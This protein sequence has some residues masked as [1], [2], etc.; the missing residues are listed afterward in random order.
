M[1]TTNDKPK[2]YIETIAPVPEWG[3]EGITADQVIRSALV[4]AQHQLEWMR[5]SMRVDMHLERGTDAHKAAARQTMLHTT[6][7][8]TH[9]IVADLFSTIQRV[10]PDEADGIAGLFVAQSESGDYYPEIIWDWMTARGIDPERIRTET[11]AE[12]AA[13]KITETN[14]AEAVEKSN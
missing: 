2:S 1:S 9:S 4:S 14:T 5:E 6:N 11:A 12:I 13:S 8:V 10:A 7:F 3:D